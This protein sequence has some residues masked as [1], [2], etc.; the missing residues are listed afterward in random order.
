MVVMNG[1]LGQGT[2]RPIKDDKG[3]CEVGT[4]SKDGV[5]TQRYSRRR[6]HK[7]LHRTHHWPAGQAAAR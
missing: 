2:R 7:D 4:L 6:Q 1:T 5:V 3:V